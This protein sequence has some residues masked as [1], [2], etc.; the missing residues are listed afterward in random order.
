MSKGKA[1]GR[2]EGIEDST[3][4]GKR[5]RGDRGGDLNIVGYEGRERGKSV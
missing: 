5:G 3:K 4:G 1:R 2:C